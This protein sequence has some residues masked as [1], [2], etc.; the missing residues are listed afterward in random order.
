MRIQAAGGKTRGFEEFRQ[1][2]LEQLIGVWCLVFV[3]QQM[4]ISCP[5]PDSTPLQPAYTDI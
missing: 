5:K 3:V 1:T 4:K 2:R